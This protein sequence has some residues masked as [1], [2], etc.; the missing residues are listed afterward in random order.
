MASVEYLNETAPE[1]LSFVL[2]LKVLSG[3]S[4]GCFLRYEQRPISNFNELLFKCDPGL[5]HNKVRR[6]V[7]RNYA[8]NNK[9]ST[10]LKISNLEFLFKTKLARMCVILTFLLSDIRHVMMANKS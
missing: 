1:R 2:L 3:L 6:K 7:V 4:R 10:M 5:K 9:K 8:Q